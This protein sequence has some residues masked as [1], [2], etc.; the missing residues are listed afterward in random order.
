LP[1]PQGHGSLRPGLAIVVNH[2]PS[3]MRPMHS[4]LLADATFHHL[5]LAFDQDIANTARQ[6]PCALCAGVL[7]SGRYR[8]GEHRSA[9][10]LLDHLQTR[11]DQDVPDFVGQKSGVFASG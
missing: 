7:H 11:G 1:L 2:E 9:V 4:T 10:G 6:E 5:L 8:R 3:R